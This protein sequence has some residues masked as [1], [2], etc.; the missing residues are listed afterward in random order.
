MTGE[1]LDWEL[2][3]NQPQPSWALAAAGQLTGAIDPDV[4]R[5][6]AAD[7][8]LLLEEWGTMLYA[9][10]DGL[11]RWGGPLV[12]SRFQG[13]PWRVEAAGISTYPHGMPYL[14][15]YR[16]ASVDPAEAIRHIWT[17]LQSFP[18]GNLG[19]QVVG[20]TPA[21]VGSTATPYQLAWGTRRTAARRSTSC[22]GKPRWSGSRRSAGRRRRPTPSTTP[23]GSGTRGPG[24]AART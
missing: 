23:C 14:G 13:A 4:G 16:Q 10:A 2:P 22:P 21:R 8:R 11:L 24:E 7:G 18:N 3:L 9:E 5:L 15:E 12:H 1:V 6:R 17:H 19:V 20:S